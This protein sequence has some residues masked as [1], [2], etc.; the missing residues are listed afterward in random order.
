MLLRMRRRRQSG[1][2]VG[3]WRQR[4]KS[5]EEFAEGRGFEPSTLCFWASRLKR[6]LAEHAEATPAVRMA[7]VVR[8]S[9]PTV[10]ARDEDGVIVEIREARIIV[11]RGFDP[12]LSREV[13]ASLRAV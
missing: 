7:Q 9:T 10:A 3:E 2:R 12:T 6:K 5:P 11:R 13:I 4:G 1:T 8:R